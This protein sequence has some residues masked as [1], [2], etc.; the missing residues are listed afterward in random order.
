M[1]H[2]LLYICT[3]T[4]LTLAA[5]KGGDAPQED[6]AAK[7]AKEY[8]DHLLKG[9]VEEYMKGVADADSLP[10]SYRSQLIDATQQLLDAQAKE[11]GGIDSVS[12]V[13]SRTDSLTRQTVALL[14]LCF[15]DSLREEVAVPMVE[16][17]G[18]WKMK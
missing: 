5:C 13:G 15:K 16:R 6:L 9:E 2:T 18:V 7:A 17:G 3:A 1:K 8:Y 14:T 12:A 10:A 11:H 4:L